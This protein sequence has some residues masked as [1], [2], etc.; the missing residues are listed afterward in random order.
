MKTY[1]ERT[2]SVLA[3][4]AVKKRQRKI[5]TAS[6]SG[7]VV[8]ALVLVLFLPFSTTPPSVRAYCN[9]PYYDLIQKLNEA[10][11]RK[12]EYKNRFESIMHSFDRLSKE[13][14]AENTLN[15][16]A[17]G[18]VQ[19]DNLS[20]N[21]PDVGE[22]AYQEVT[23]NQVAGVI[24]A[25]LFKRSDKYLYYLRGNTLSVYSLEGEA[26]KLVGEFK[27]DFTG[28]FGADE[29]SVPL[30]YGAEM[31]LSQ[32]GG[33][34]TL[35][36]QGSRKDLGSCTILVSLDVTDPANIQQTGFALF[37]G[38]YLTSRLVEGGLLLIYN[39]R[40]YKN[41]MDFS[42]PATF[43]PSYIADGQT[44]LFPAEDILCPED[45]TDTRYTVICKLSD[46][47]LQVQDTAALLSFS[48]EVY[49][50][51]TTLYATH[52]FAENRKE[53]EQT[54]S[55]AM[56]RIAGFDYTGD[57]LVKTGEVTVRG[58]VKDQY[59][60]DEYAGILRI[61]TTT[62]EN[63]GRERINGSVAVSWIEDSRTNCDL[64]CVDLADW[65]VRSSVQDFAPWGEEVTSARFDGTKAYV[66]TA[67][68]VQ[69]TDPVFFFDLS[70]V[71]NITWTDTGTIDG[72]SSSMINFGDEIS[73]GIGINENRELKL[74]IYGRYGNLVE[75]VANFEYCGSY[76]TEYKSYYIDRENSIIG[77]AVQDWN[78]GNFYY[79]L[80]HYDGYQFRLLQKVPVSIGYFSTVRS[81]IV[82]GWLYLLTDMDFQTKQIW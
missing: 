56:T 44:H 73:L 18:A 10:T 3:K 55:T 4:L 57:S 80:L 11:Y 82:D 81:V 25:D 13:T 64:Y 19:D 20:D 14:F 77:L 9:S 70:D 12:P 37:Q 31:Y 2:Q 48:Q 51:G 72:F 34:V 71:D 6:V 17:P 74:E 21:M 65:S 8:L 52:A 27:P 33:T 61:V 22:D 24:E 67:L 43:V 60:M 66:C 78:D 1:Y 58:R 40:F 47:E 42:E 7:C 76:S 46:K 15:P 69:L 26:S 54:V 23:D 28:S 62:T 39:Y 49:V 36:A 41:D 68:V 50:S 75:S 63:R 29:M 35:V 79:L 5:L 30:Y 38:S 59:S 32:D 53:G 45:V 16:E